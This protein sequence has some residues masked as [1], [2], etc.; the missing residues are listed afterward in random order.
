MTGGG[1]FGGG[2]FF[3]GNGGVF[4][5]GVKILTVR[6]RTPDLLEANLV[7]ASEIATPSARNDIG[8][9]FKCGLL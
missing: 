3:C 6:R 7:G 4:E 9:L 2:L 5:Y 8:G 1:S